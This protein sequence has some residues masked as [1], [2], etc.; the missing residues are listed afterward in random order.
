MRL[1]RLINTIN[2]YSHIPTAGFGCSLSRI[3]KNTFGV[4]RFHTLPL[5][6]FLFDLR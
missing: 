3:T 2:P 1:N 4:Q 6:E 5:G